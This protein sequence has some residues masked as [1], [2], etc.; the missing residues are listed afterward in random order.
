MESPFPKKKPT[1]PKLQTFTPEKP[2]YK[3]YC[4]PEYLQQPGFFKGFISETNPCYHTFNVE[5]VKGLN[6]KGITEDYFWSCAE[7]S[8]ARQYMRDVAVAA[9]QEQDAKMEK[10]QRTE[11]EVMSA[12]E[13]AAAIV[14]MIPWG[15]FGPSD[16]AGAKDTEVEVETELKETSWWFPNDFGKHMETCFGK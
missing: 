3:K 1:Y 7:R 11:E 6:T 12:V 9:I 8:K 4:S 10:M 13:M 2:S 5:L 16:E 15:S 14:G